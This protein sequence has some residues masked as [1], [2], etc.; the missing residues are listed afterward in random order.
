MPTFNTAKQ[1]LRLK[2]VYYGPGQSGKTTN[3]QALH[4][5]FP[6]SARGALVSLD[7]ESERTLFFDYFPARIGTLRDWKVQVDFFTVPGQSFYNATRREV[8]RNADGVV[9]VADSCPDREQANLVA[10]DNLET[11]LRSF[12]RDL[13]TLPM[14]FQW[15]KRDAAR[16]TP[17]TVLER[18]LNRRANPSE[19][20]IASQL[21]GVW[22]TQTLILREALAS[23]QRQGVRTQPI[24]MGEVQAG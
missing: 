8:L 7:T 11:N 16:A 3:L 18:Q 5:T 17:T 4:D 15:N 1:L 22:E 2:I 13:D 21:I 10:L 6:S 24:E 23:L 19:P 9:F 20:A 12:G 14:V